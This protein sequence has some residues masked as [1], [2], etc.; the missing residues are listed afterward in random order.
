MKYLHPQGCFPLVLLPLL[1]WGPVV[2]G[3]FSWLGRG[4]LGDRGACCVGFGARQD[5]L[6]SPAPSL[7]AAGLWAHCSPSLGL[8]V[9][10]WKVGLEDPPCKDWWRSGLGRPLRRVCCL[11]RACDLTPP[12]PSLCVWGAPRSTGCPSAAP[13]PPCLPSP[14][15]VA[16]GPPGIAGQAGTG[17]GSGR[18]RRRLTSRWTD[19]PG[20]LSCGSSPCASSWWRTWHRR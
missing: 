19:R 18:G 20:P 16:R 3:L 11:R 10:T 9:P 4:A 14:W 6:S 13:P 8:R 12:C 2:Q 1:S 15:R 17:W 5:W 7:L